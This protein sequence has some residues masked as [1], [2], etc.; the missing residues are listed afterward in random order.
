MGNARRS[1]RRLGSSNAAWALTLGLCASLLA[2]AAAFASAG[3]DAVNGG[4][5]N[6]TKTVGGTVNSPPV[7][8]AFSAGEKLTLTVTNPGNAASLNTPNSLVLRLGAAAVNGN[9]I[10]N[11]TTL[12][13]TANGT[14]VFAQSGVGETAAASITIA[15][16]CQAVAAA[17][18]MTVTSSLNPSAVGQSVTFTATVSG[19]GGTP[20][21]TVNFLDG[22]AVIGNG[23]LARRRNF[24]DRKPYAGK[25]QHHRRLRWC[26]KLYR[27]YVGGFDSGGRRHG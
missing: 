27:E 12:S 5:L 14:E 18:T 4:T 26:R 10:A 3:C 6:F 16:V 17:T 15:V 19:T 7:N 11:G 22:G 25:P 24:H 1:K 2:P 21:G 13:L 9:S 8:A 20:T 23:A